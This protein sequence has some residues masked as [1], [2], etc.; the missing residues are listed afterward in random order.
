[1]LNSDIERSVPGVAGVVKDGILPGYYGYETGQAAVGD[2]FDWLRRLTGHPNFIQLGR[3]AALLPPGAEGVLCVDWFHGC[4]TP[5]MDGNLKGAFVGLALHHRPEHLYRALLE[6]SAFGLRW[7]VELLREGGVEVRKLVA[8]GGLPHHNPLVVQ[9][10]S[11]VLGE[12]ISVHPSK[13][14][15]AL[16]AAILGSLAANLFASPKAAIRAMATPRPQDV[17][18]YKP[19]RSNRKIY[20]RLYREYRR[21]G[22]FLSHPISS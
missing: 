18:T 3:K 19:N 2:A 5:L 20:D 7:I 10:Y 1:M 12:P 22:E 17:V 6:A 8:T 16:G 21:Q 14:G 9:V 13:Q 15:S 4:R 11:D